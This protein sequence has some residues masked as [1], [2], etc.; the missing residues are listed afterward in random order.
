MLD[1]DERNLIQC[2]QQRDTEAFGELY[3]RHFDQ[4]FRYVL[5]RVGEQA[6]AEDLTGD[7]FVSVLEALERYEDRGVPFS[8]WLYKIANARVIDHWRRAHWAGGSIDAERVSI[9]VD[10]PSG[11]VLAYKFLAESLKKLTSEQQEVIVLKFIEG[12]SIAEVAQRTGRS[13]GAIKSLQHRALAS[14]ARLMEPK[15]VSAPIGDGN[16]AL[17]FA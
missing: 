15:T 5:A 2:A 12:Y 7:V 13:I 4:I 9:A 10:A 14:L 8:A 16:R 3:R 1:S 11:D 6:L 17:S